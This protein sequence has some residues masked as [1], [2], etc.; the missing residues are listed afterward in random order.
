MS[1]MR[2]SL[3]VI[4]CGLVVALSVPLNAVRQP[5]RARHGMAVAMESQAAD[6]GIAVLQKG[7]NAV[8]AAVAMGFA[9]AATHPFAGNLG[10]G[11]FMLIR[12][13]DGRSTFIDFREQAPGKA[14]RNMYLD[15][16]GKLTKDSIE[17]WRSSGVPGTV[18]GFEMATSKYGKRTWAENMAP[19]IALAKGFPISYALAESLKRSRDL[20]QDPESKRIFQKGGAFFDVGET[21]AQPELADTLERIAKNGPNEFYEGETAKRFAAEMTKHGGLITEADLKAYKAIERVPLKGT[22]KN[23]T[24]ITSPPASSGGI[25]LLEMLGILNGTNYEKAGSGSAS[26]IHYLAEAMRRAYADRNEYVGDP[27]FVKVPIAGLLDP[28]YH[29]KLRATIDPERAT[30]SAVVKPGRPVGSESMETTHYSVVDSEGTAVAV[31]YTLNGGFGNGITVPGLG[32]LLNNE[33]D[34]FSAKPGEANM[35]GLVQGENNAIQP[36]KRPLS[37]M[38]P[39]IIEKDG[40]LFMTAGAPG[41]S[42]ISTAVAQVILNVLDFGMNVQDAVDAPRVHHQW[43]PDKLSLEHGISPDTVALLKSRGYDVDYAPGV[44]LAQVAAIVSDGGW[45]QGGSDGRSA[46][47]KA[48][49]Y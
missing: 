36:G 39:T 41:G 40:K 35:F 46:A 22:Y 21:L 28:A 49:G 38:T 29:A 27:A 15:A 44:V 1:R 20:A 10:G 33:M 7:G 42:R 24:I 3:T 14:S 8:D 4:L 16:A 45:L 17:G 11:G 23:Y 6:V 9:M 37:S 26:A 34:D 47:G 13:A 43:Q 30:P 5:L 32:F 19:A 18:R 31:T 2:R 48:A 12:F 25:A